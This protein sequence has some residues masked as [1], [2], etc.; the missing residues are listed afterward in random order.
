MFFRKLPHA[1][2]V[3]NTPFSSSGI[4][5]SVDSGTVSDESNSARA[6]RI[7]T[8]G[9]RKLIAVPEMVWSAFSLT[10]AHACSAPN[11]APARPPQKNKIQGSD[12]KC[13]TVAPTNAPMV[14]MPSMPMLTTPLFSEK[15]EPSAA[16][17]SG[18][19]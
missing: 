4:F 15:H 8:P 17:S 16:N 5:C 1:E 7:A 11:T 2:F 6:S 12:V 18:G 13:E 3:G 10:V 14:I 9:A 19:V